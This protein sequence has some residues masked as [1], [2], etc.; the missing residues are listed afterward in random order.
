MCVLVTVTVVVLGVV[1]AIA[2]RRYSDRIKAIWDRI[3]GG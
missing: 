2:W 3:I 1:A